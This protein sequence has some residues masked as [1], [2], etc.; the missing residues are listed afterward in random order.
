MPT[1]TKKPAVKWLP[2]STLEI[3]WDTAQRR[4]DERHARRI[5][6]NLDPQA[7]GVLAVTNVDSNGH[8]HVI[9]GQH[10][11][12]ALRILGDWDDQKVPCLVHD[13]DGPVEAAR[14]FDRIFNTA[15]RPQAI[16]RFLVRVQAGE[17]IESEIAAVVSRN[18][19]KVGWESRP[20]HISCVTALLSVYNAWGSPK[21]HKQNAGGADAVDQTLKVL[22]AAWPDD[23]DAVHQAL[24]KGMGGVVNAY[25]D[26][27]DT[28]RLVEKLRKSGTAAGLVGRGRGVREVMKITHASGCARVITDIYNKGLRSGR[29]D[30]SY[31]AW[32]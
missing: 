18:G 26:K 17:R 4:L 21:T 7:F 13:I 16:D 12:A 14:M 20:G 19:L 24:V 15:K 31:W 28:E 5:A 9:D 29:L 8:Y 3:T 23:R 2:V 27:L 6:D 1:T 30:Q 10:R 11:V 25:H 32:R 22:L